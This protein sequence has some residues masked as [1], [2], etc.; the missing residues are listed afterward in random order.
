MSLE[1]NYKTLY[2]EPY[3]KST[4]KLLSIWAICLSELLL[5]YNCLYLSNIKFELTY[6][7]FS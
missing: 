5:E 6:F 3:L 7:L 1:N 2:I 4:L